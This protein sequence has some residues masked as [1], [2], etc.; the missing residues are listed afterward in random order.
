MRKETVEKVKSATIVVLVLIIVFGA[1]YFT[2]EL[3]ERNNKDVSTGTSSTD[4]NS[5]NAATS[6]DSDISTVQGVSDALST[7]SSLTREG[8]NSVVSAISDQTSQLVAKM[9]Q[10]LSIISN[11]RVGSTYNNKLVDLKG[12]LT[13]NAQ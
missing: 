4:T 6:T 10:I 11:G 2:S 12:G 5:S 3:Q 13:P 8:F 1:S 7:S 9:D